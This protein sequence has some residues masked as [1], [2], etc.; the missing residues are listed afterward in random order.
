[1]QCYFTFDYFIQFLYLKL[2]DLP[3]KPE[4]H[5]LFYLYLCSIVFIC[6]VAFS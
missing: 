2:L 4:K 6:A 3:K 1:M 5:C